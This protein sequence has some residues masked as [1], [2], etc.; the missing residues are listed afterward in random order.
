MIQKND[1]ELPMFQVRTM[2]ERVKN[3]LWLRRSY[4]WLFGFFAAIALT[5]ALAGVYGVISYGV[6][7]RTNEVV[8]Q[9]GKL[10]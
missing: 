8:G 5:M 3:L 7:Q 2:S 1:P 10:S 4:L 9:A 6:T